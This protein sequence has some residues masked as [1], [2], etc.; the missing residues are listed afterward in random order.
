MIINMVVCVGSERRR[1]RCCQCL[2]VNLIKQVQVEVGGWVNDA[3]GGEDQTE[4][5]LSVG[6]NV[7]LRV[8]CSGKRTFWVWFDSFVRRKRQL[9]L[10]QK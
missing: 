2:L 10:Y 9:L 1:R 5:R 8:L 4:R 7:G 3:R 6:S